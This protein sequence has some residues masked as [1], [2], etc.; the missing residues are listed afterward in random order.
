MMIKLTKGKSNSVEAEMCSAC[1]GAC[2]K[3]MPGSA[4]PDDFEG[5]REGTHEARVAI[6][7]AL[8]ATGKWTL[9]WFEGDA[10]QPYDKWHSTERKQSYYIRPAIKG[11]EG[12][13]YHAGWRGR[14]TFLTETGCSFAHDERPTECRSLKPSK[15]FPQSCDGPHDKQTTAQAW[16][17]FEAE[18]K[19][20]LNVFNANPSSFDAHAIDIDAVMSWRYPS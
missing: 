2:C 15:P 16:L 12:R 7:V 4:H 14:C 6:I 9:D 13:P 20:A 19:E 1:K 3:H 11:Y 10:T 5:L 18:I 17:P 8:I